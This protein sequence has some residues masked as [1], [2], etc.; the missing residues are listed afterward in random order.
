MRARDRTSSIGSL[1]P[2]LASLLLLPY[3]QCSSAAADVK[4][5]AWKERAS[6][7]CQLLAPNFALYWQVTNSTGSVSFSV[8]VTPTQD[9][10]RGLQWV[11]KKTGCAA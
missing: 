7:R 3:V 4:C 9:L 8:D 11:R 2:V 10:S 1:L 5:G 6:W